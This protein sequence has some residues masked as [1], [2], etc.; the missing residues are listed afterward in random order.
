MASLEHHQPAVLARDL[1]YSNDITSSPRHPKEYLI[2]LRPVDW[3]IDT[4]ELMAP[5]SQAE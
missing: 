3:I 1:E 2:D 5:C 4:V